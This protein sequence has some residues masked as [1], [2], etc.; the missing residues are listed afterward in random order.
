MIVNLIKSRQMFSLTLPNKV[1]GQYW[2]HDIDREG[3]M[4]EL[5]SVEA[6]KGEWVLK[7]NKRVSVLN[8]DNV[9]VD[10]TILFPQGFFNL[11][12]ADDNDRVILF[13]ESIGAGRQIFRKIMVRSVD[14]FSIG[15]TKDN[16]FCFDNKFVS[17]RHA[18][19]SYDGKN[20]G[21]LD[22]DL[23]PE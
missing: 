10:N 16:N 8:A 12:I 23:L 1:K 13:A 15:R 21:I 19:L 18:K 3:K 5:I 17:S 9:P 14:T 2:L 4:R 6:V 7:S 11:K 22:T 20:W